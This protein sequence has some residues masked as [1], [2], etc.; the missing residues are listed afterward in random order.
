MW[1]ISKVK[2][3]SDDHDNCSLKGHD[4]RVMTVDTIKDSD[5]N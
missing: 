1:G 5:A 3:S 4:C 2:T